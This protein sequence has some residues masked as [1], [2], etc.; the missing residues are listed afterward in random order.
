MSQIEYK[1]GYEFI[2]RCQVRERAILFHPTFLDFRVMAKNFDSE[3]FHDST[4]AYLMGG[5]L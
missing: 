1:T 3:S 4:G 2:A 5:E